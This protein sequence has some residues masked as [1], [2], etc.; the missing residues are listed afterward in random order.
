MPFRWRPERRLRRLAGL[1]V[2]MLAAPA[3]PIS[4]TNPILRSMATSGCGSGVGVPRLGA[5]VASLRVP[6]STPQLF[7]PALH[8]RAN[9]LDRAASSAHL[10]L[11]ENQRDWARTAAAPVG[12]A[13]DTGSRVPLK[14]SAEEE[15]HT[16]RV[17]VHAAAQLFSRVLACR[18]RARLKSAR[19]RDNRG[20]R[21][22][23]L[24]R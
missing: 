17:T 18:V 2:R 9:G 14:I 21:G 19:G 13:A 4:L 24:L 8:V 1:E 11:I 10:S 23:A 16:C 15:C 5:G 3:R 7:E 22:A 20:T 6:K 12:I